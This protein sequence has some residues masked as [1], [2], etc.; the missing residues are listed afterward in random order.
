MFPS[1]LLPVR[2][3]ETSQSCQEGTWQASWHSKCSINGGSR[4]VSSRIDKVLTNPNW[5]KWATSTALTSLS[6]SKRIQFS[7]YLISTLE[8][9][10]KV[11]SKVLHTPLDSPGKIPKTLLTPFPGGKVPLYGD[12]KS[13]SLQFLSS[14]LTLAP[15]A[16]KNNS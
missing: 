3:S 6:T 7:P 15:K 5:H 14:S 12:A 2:C 13:A 11:D 16:L 8:R 4:H 1:L 10:L 9:N